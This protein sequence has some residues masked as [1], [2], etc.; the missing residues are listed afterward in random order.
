MYLSV[1][2]KARKDRD[3]Q[4][5]AYLEKIDS[6]V[7]RLPALQR[8][9][10]GA[11]D[12]HDD[13]GAKKILGYV[14]AA[15]NDIELIPFLEDGRV[16][17]DKAEPA[18]QRADVATAQVIMSLWSQMPVA[19]RENYSVLMTQNEYEWKSGDFATLSETRKGMLAL[20]AERWRRTPDLEEEG[21]CIEFLFAAIDVP[22]EEQSKAAEQVLRAAIDS[23]DIFPRLRRA[24]HAALARRWKRV[25][26]WRH[27]EIM[28]V[29]RTGW[30]RN[31]KADEFA[32]VIDMDHMLFGA[33]PSA[34]AF[35]MKMVQEV[36]AFDA[37]LRKFV[38]DLMTRSREFNYCINNPQI[39]Y[40]KLDA[41]ELNVWFG[42]DRSEKHAALSRKLCSEI[43]RWLVGRSFSI[44]LRCYVA[45][46]PRLD[47]HR[48]W[49]YCDVIKP[50]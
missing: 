37:E 6:T 17:W 43:D 30:A 14:T 3:W 46:E 2:D 33:S 22:F 40:M 27:H 28:R 13:D 49:E 18:R 24:Y 42:R 34:H 41:V 9:F 23:D 15:I 38:V 7:Y 36:A 8:L 25:S 11:A 16:R 12:A 4:T 44:H 20:I 45:V 5:V 47:S 48:S 31:R 21:R 32:M 35:A 39:E 19:K 26:D 1:V 50:V 10:L 29:L